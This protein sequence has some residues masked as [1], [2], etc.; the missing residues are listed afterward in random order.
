MMSVY[1]IGYTFHFVH[2]LDTDIDEDKNS[3]I[4]KKQM[5]FAGLE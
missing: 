1:G 3:V 5:N 2:P 4:W